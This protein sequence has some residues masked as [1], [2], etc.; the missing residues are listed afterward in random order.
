M[1]MQKTDTL[2]FKL[3]KLMIA[4]SWADGKIDNS[5]INALK[6]LLFSLPEL[7]AR[8]WAEL[9]MYMDSHVSESE[10]EIILENVLQSLQ[11]TSEKNTHLRY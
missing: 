3:A 11:S 7:D 5:E 10:R 4:I 2:T 8:E 9:E 6:D 1:I